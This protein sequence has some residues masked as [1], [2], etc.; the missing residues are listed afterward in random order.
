MPRLVGKGRFLKKERVEA[1]DIALFGSF[2]PKG[3]VQNRLAMMIPHWV[4]RGLRVEIVVFR[5]GQLFYPDVLAPLVTLHRLSAQTKLGAAIGL[6][7]YLRLRQPRVTL[8][9]ARIPNLISLSANLLAGRRGRAVVCVTNPPGRSG[10]ETPQWR[11]RRR[12]KLRWM[13]WLYPSADAVVAISEGVKADLV[14]LAGLSAE[15]VRVIYNGVLTPEVLRKAETPL[16]HPWFN[17]P[18]T[19]VVVSA[20]RLSLQ[21]DFAGLIRAFAKLRARRAARLV[22]LGEGPERQGLQDLAQSLGVAVD[23]QLPG[24]TENPYAY[25]ARAQVF[26]LSSVWEGF[27]NVV[28]EALCLGTPVVATACPGGPREIL[29]EGRWGRLVAPG[30]AQAL[31]DAMEKALGEQRTDAPAPSR[32]RH[33]RRFS[34]EYA[35]AEY[36]RVMGLSEVEVSTDDDD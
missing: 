20:G 12:G 15:R 35:A 22:I 16:A 18:A 31:A 32:E 26:V 6:A 7:R 9:S 5:D 27:G 11:R 14:R 29:G 34:A 21:K 13:R 2:A 24:Y 19:P 30:D 23:C 10:A 4:Q 33:C 3:G 17:D 28:A 36:L 8:T 1:V 25:M